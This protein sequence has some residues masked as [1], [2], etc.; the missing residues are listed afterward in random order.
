MK[1]LWIE[2]TAEEFHALFDYLTKLEK[3]ELS[4]EIRTILEEVRKILF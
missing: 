4:E 3:L 2:L 1:S